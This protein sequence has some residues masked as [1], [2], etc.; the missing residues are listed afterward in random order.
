MKTVGIKL[1]VEDILKGFDMIGTNN[2]NL[3]AMKYSSM[4][5][6]PLNGS[7]HHKEIHFD[8]QYYEL[9]FIRSSYTY[10]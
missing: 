4:D 9:C 3:S 1:R 7:N 2:R 5:I 8:P 6:V 10:L